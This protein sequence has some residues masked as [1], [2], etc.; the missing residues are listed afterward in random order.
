MRLEPKKRTSSCLTLLVALHPVK[1]H[2]PPP[3]LREIDAAN[4]CRRRARLVQCK[5]SICRSVTHAHGTMYGDGARAP[6]VDAPNF[7]PDE[8]TLQT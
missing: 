1:H 6:H 5:R 7:H 3:N 4:C 2:R 8:K